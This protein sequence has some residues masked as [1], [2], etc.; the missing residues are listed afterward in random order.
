MTI[1]ALKTKEKKTLLSVIKEQSDNGKTIL[2]FDELKRMISMNCTNSETAEELFSLMHK[3]KI[4]VRSSKRNPDEL[5]IKYLEKPT[6]SQTNS[7]IMNCINSY[8]LYFQLFK[9]TGREDYNRVTKGRYSKL[10]LTHLIE[11]HKLKPSEI[12]I[13]IKTIQGYINGMSPSHLSEMSLSPSEFLSASRDIRTD[14]HKLIKNRLL[15]YRIDMDGIS[16][17]TILTRETLDNLLL[18]DSGVSVESQKQHHHLYDLIPHA[19]IEEKEVLYSEDSTDFFNDVTE[20]TKSCKRDDNISVL[21]YGPS[22]TGK[23]EFAYQLA[24]KTNSDIMQMDFPQISSKWIGETEKNIKQVFAKYTEYT[25]Q[26]E[27]RTILLINEAD[28]LMNRRVSISQSNDIHANQNQTQLLERLESFKGIV[29]ATTNLFQNIDEAF[30]RRF[31]FK[32]KIDFPPSSVKLKALSD[33]IIKNYL[34]DA[35]LIKIINSNWSIAQLRNCEYKV[36]MI[37]KIRTISESTV[38][39]LLKE[40]GLINE[41]KQ[42]GF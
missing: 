8:L 22:G 39:N 24:K 25:K 18:K 35:T 29:I 11:K 3:G 37:A 32:Q 14:K 30:H 19:S 7:E 12:N 17:S 26:S 20:I 9:R 34:Q 31:L 2:E 15:N 40:D 23:T 6:K 27:R 38:L 42:I 28:G 10:N 21:L 16:I 13:L 4:A 5:Q 41:R 36:A 1:K 33:S